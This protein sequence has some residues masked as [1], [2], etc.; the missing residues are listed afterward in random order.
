[1]TFFWNFFP[2]IVNCALFGIGSWWKFFLFPRKIFKIVE[3]WTEI[4]HQILG[5]WE[6]QTI[7]NL[8]KNAW[9]VQKSY[10]P[11]LKKTAHCVKRYWLM[12]FWAQRSEKKIMLTMFWDMKECI[13]IDLH[14]KRA[15]VNRYSCCQFLRKNSPYLLNY[16]HF[17]PYKIS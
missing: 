5:S 6:V 8:Q 3:N 14:E 15:T 17:F 1:M 7:W 9:C 12:K 13:T 10:E 4:Y 16:P 2:T 11:E